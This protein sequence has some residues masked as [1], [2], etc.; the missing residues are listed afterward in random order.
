MQHRIIHYFIVEYTMFE[1]I[2]RGSGFL[3]H[4][5]RC[6]IG[7]LFLIGQE[8]EQP[9]VILELLDVEKNPWYNKI[10][11]FYFFITFIFQ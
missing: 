3:W 11:Y 1:V 4:Q 10:Y 5:I 8:K 7:V 6:I 9:Q 2:I